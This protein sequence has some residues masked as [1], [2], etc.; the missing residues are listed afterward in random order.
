MS[1][2]IWAILPICILIGASSS[3]A[4]P[5]FETDCARFAQVYDKLREAHVSLPPLTDYPGEKVDFS[6]GAFLNGV[7]DSVGS[8][9]CDAGHKVESVELSFNGT[10]IEDDELR[11]VALNRHHDVSIALL[12]AFGLGDWSWAKYLVERSGKRAG[13]LAVRSAYRGDDN[14]RG[15][16]VVSLDDLYCLRVMIDKEGATV[17]VELKTTEHED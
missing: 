6:T 9:K 3:H 16:E 14:P 8:L 2:V 7:K 12:A 11:R 15:V 10:S 13:N 4:G 5:A 1:H 17:S